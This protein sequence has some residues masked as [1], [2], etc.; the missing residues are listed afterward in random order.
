MLGNTGQAAVGSRSFT[1]DGG[2]LRPGMLG[3]GA[4]DVVAWGAHGNGTTDDSL[5]LQ[6][7]LDAVG[8]N[9]GVVVL[10][11]GRRFRISRALML[12]SGTWLTGGG[13]L[14]AAPAASWG[15]SVTGLTNVQHEAEILTDSDIRIDGI[16]LDW[17]LATSGGGGH[18]IYL[19]RVRHVRVT[20]CEVEGGSSAVALLGCDD[21]LI[22]DCRLAGFANC[23]A[24]HW[25]NPRNARVQGCHIET[26]SSAQAVNFNPEPTS[27]AGGG[28]IARGFAMT[29][30]T[31]VSSEADP[32]P[33]QIEPLVAGNWVE[34]V[35]IVGNVLRNA[36]LVLRGD[37]RGA[38]VANN[39][40]S[41]FLG[42]AEPINSYTWKGA[43]P[44]GVV[45]I[46]NVVRDAL[47]A[48]PNLGVI[49]VECATGTIALNTVLGSGH[50]VAAFYRG[51]SGAQLVS[52][53]AE[54]P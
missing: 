14:V 54:V 16:G 6:A 43:D 22:E 5:A 42:N 24:D 8:E 7:A 12:K 31:I 53:Y 46:A 3:A 17:T 40:L 48:A 19:R 30:C 34:D 51:S 35:S 37:V 13:T 39:V 45:A 25:D 28:Q 36:T 49:R 10:P 27:N 26:T 18:P 29:G 32:T 23:G 9:G 41:G 21:T 2:T 38:V 15:G 52:N 33:C 44:K 4:I 1:R 47:T 20:G 11:R 50:S